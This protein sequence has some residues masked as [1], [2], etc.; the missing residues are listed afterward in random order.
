[1]AG[2]L[3]STEMGT[4]VH[5]AGGRGAQRQ[6]LVLGGWRRGSSDLQCLLS[7]CKALSSNPTAI[8]SKKRF[9]VFPFSFAVGLRLETQTGRRIYKFGTHDHFLGH[10]PC[11]ES[12]AQS[13]RYGQAQWVLM[14][15]QKR[16]LPLQLSL[17]MCYCYYFPVTCVSSY[18]R[19]TTH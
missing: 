4:T 13:P 12:I 15:I 19:E 7:K 16:R 5:E 1:V 17:K 9:G 6:K 3:L 18:Q 14:E 10:L 2:R 8:K 11:A